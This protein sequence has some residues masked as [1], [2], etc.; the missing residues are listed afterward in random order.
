MPNTESTENKLSGKEMLLSLLQKKLGS[1][2][3][4]LEKN[5]SEQ[6]SSLTM[7]SKTFSEFDTNLHRLTKQIE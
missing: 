3:S 6:M 4:L 1:S 5:T 7:T 2:L